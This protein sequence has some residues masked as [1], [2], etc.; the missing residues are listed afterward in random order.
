MAKTECS[1]TFSIIAAPN[2]NHRLR[3]RS[4]ER[5][6]LGPIVYRYFEQ[7]QVTDVLRLGKSPELERGTRVKMRTRERVRILLV[8][9]NRLTRKGHTTRYVL[10]LFL[11]DN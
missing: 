2:G 4:Q 10:I 7:L 11:T 8:R 5:A 1:R 9:R 6:A 3:E